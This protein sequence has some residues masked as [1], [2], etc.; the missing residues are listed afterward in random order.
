MFESGKVNYTL[1]YFDNF[2][3]KIKEN[4]KKNTTT[5]MYGIVLLILLQEILKNILSW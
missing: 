2:S 1:S 5:Y 4:L 3:K